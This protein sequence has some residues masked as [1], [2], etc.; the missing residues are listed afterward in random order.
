VLAGSATL[1][2]CDAGWVGRSALGNKG[3]WVAPNGPRGSAGRSG[4]ECTCKPKGATTPPSSDV[5]LAV[6]LRRWSNAL[7]CPTGP[8]RPAKAGSGQTSRS[9]RRQGMRCTPRSLAELATTRHGR[10]TVTHP[11]GRASGW[12]NPA[13]VSVAA[14]DGE[15]RFVGQERGTGTCCFFGKLGS[16]T[17]VVTPGC[18]HDDASRRVGQPRRHGESRGVK[19]QYRNGPNP[20]TGASC[21]MLATRRQSAEVVKTARAARG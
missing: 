20:M 8:K 1:T 7:R 6:R 9:A 13:R 18:R 5:G 3:N 2:G 12:S 16:A 4:Q 21:N 17:Q 15:Q 10:A 19:W 14:T 11:R